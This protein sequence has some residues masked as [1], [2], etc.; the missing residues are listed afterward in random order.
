MACAVVRAGETVIPV[1][2][3]A[4]SMTG[5]PVEWMMVRLFASVSEPVATEAIVA[6][7]WFAVPGSISIVSPAA[8]PAELA[9]LITF[10]CGTT[11]GGERVPRS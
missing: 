2:G 7:S 9:T 5:A 3:F 8:K 11:R 4:V 1:P 10:G 6:V